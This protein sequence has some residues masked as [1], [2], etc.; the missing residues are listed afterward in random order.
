[1]GWKGREEESGGNV[2]C[3]FSERE[4]LLFSF[5]N[6]FLPFCPSLLS[7]FFLKN[8]K[9]YLLFYFVLY[10]LVLFLSGIFGWEGKLYMSRE[11]RET[12]QKL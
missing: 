5:F 4:M 11:G 10:I 9:N 7:S 3:N 1:M 12:R 2:N 6:L 8:K